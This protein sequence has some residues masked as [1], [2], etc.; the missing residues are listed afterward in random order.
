MKVLIA[1]DHEVIRIGIRHI[2]QEGFTLAEIGEAYDT[3]SLIEKAISK[4]WDI[5]ISDISMPGGGGIEALK[6]ILAH[7]SSQRILVITAYPEEQYAK[8]VLQAG[9]SGFL[10]KDSAPEKLI[11]AVSIILSGD[12][13]VPPSAADGL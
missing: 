9:A 3:N 11:D 4:D 8:R 10:T 2:L 6:K 1:D 13:F 12:R 5:I 7:N